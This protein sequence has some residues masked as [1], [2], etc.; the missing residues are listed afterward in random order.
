MPAAQYIYLILTHRPIRRT[1]ILNHRIYLI[2]C[3][4][5]SR[6]SKGGCA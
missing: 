3:F 4:T 6:L 1:P 5:L 2:T